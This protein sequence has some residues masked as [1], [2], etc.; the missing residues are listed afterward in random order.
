MLRAS[1]TP[2]ALLRVSRPPSVA[3]PASSTRPDHLLVGGET[4]E[5]RRLTFGASAIRPPL[6]RARR[7]LGRRVTSSAATCSLR[8]PSAGRP[9][10]CRLGHPARLRQHA[11]RR[12]PP[13][14][15]YPGHCPQSDL[16][17]ELDAIRSSRNCSRTRIEAPRAR[18]TFSP[19]APAGRRWRGSLGGS[20][21][22]TSTG[23]SRRRGSRDT[24]S[25]SA[26]PLRLRHRPKEIVHVR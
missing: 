22:S 11:C 3:R 15:S 1:A 13:I 16:G 20:V 10:G 18:M 5:G 8:A 4:I 6:A 9:D 12:Y 7:V 21:R 23:A 26:R 2:R 14:R 24:D 25:S 17:A 19:R